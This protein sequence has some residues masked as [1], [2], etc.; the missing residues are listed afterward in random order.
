MILHPVVK[1][2]NIVRFESE[3]GDGDM[4]KSMIRFIIICLAPCEVF[5][6]VVVIVG[7]IDG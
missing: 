2:R 4:G 1:V 6:N 5:L 3:D 7:I